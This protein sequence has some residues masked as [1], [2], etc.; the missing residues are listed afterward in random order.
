MA[1]GKKKV[2][3]FSDLFTFCGQNLVQRR[4]NEKHFTPDWTH[5]HFSACTA[6]LYVV[7]NY[8]STAVP[9]TFWTIKFIAVG[10]L[11]LHCRKF[12]SL[13]GDGLRCVYWHY[14]LL[15]HTFNHWLIWPNIHWARNICHGLC[16]V[17]E[18][19]E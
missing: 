9:L 18:R 6:V 17:L 10:L 15:L 19:L 5:L 8:F 11:S 2:T 12:S 3:C 1:A 7:E 16:W 14:F 4:V 13:P